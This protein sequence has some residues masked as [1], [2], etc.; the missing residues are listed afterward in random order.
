MNF[1]DLFADRDIFKGRS[2][3]I[4]IMIMIIITITI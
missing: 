2:I 4:I 3:R 1:N